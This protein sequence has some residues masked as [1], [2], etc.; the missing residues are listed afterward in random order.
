MYMA[1]DI[2]FVYPYE[3][4][5]SSNKASQIRPYKMENAFK[6]FFDKKLIVS[7]GKR[8]FKNISNKENISALYMESINRPLFIQRL[9]EKDW[10]LFSDYWNL[11]RLKRRG[12]K[13]AVFYRDGFWAGN[14]L[15]EQHSFPVAILLKLSY[16]LEWYL[17]KQLFDNIYLPSIELARY[18]GEKKLNRF[19][20][21]TPGCE[22]E[23]LISTS[24]SHLNLN[25]QSNIT[26]LY[27]GGI[28]PPLND[29]TL[30][31]NL[32]GNKKNVKLVLIVRKNELKKYHN[33]YNFDYENV[34]IV[35]NKKADD[36]QDYYARS[37]ASLMLYPYHPYRYLSMPYKAFEAMGYG[38][39]LIS[40]SNCVMGEFIKTNG[41]GLALSYNELSKIFD[42]TKIL[43][44]LLQNSKK[45]V[46]NY[47]KNNTWNHRV[48]Q[49]NHDFTH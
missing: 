14:F 19:K 39:P 40:F 16:Q 48:E 12:V 44:I 41:L 31:L 33:Y 38:L 6:L 34:E 22:P 27:S 8:R 29:I 32:L 2:I 3:Q 17:I 42:N 23:N 20:L 5:K 30:M 37:D 36:I 25:N 28:A 45:N 35:V 26:L 1:D 24:S 46:I 18:M 4:I 49:V 47:A 43:R 9:I 11:W 13:L 7:T 21:L 10:H 15:F